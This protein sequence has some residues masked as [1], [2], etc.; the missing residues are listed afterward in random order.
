MA[1][2]KYWLGLEEYRQDAEV[3]QRRQNEFP[4]ELP[5]LDMVQD[6]AGNVPTKRRDF[7]KYMG[8][9]LTAATLASCEMPVRKAIPYVFAPE[10]T[11]PGIA[12]YYASTFADGSDYASILVKTRDGRPIKIEGNPQSSLTKGGTTARVQGS[13]LSLYDTNRKQHPSFD[14]KRQSWFQMDDAILSR[15]RL[16]AGQGRQIVLLTNSIVSPSTK[17]LIKD[18]SDKYGTVKHVAYDPVSYSGMLAANEQSFGKRALPHYRLDEAK[19]IVGFNADFLGTWLAPSQFAPQYAKHRKPKGEN[20]EMSRHIQF[21]SSMTITGAAAD[22]RHAMKPTQVRLALLH[23]YNQLANKMGAPII[24]GLANHTKSDQIKQVA[25]EL[26]R[27]QGQSLV[28]SGGNDKNEQL[29]V[30]AINDMLGNYGKTLDWAHESYYKQGDETALAKLIKDMDNGQVGAIIIHDCN[31]VYDNPL[32]AAFKDAVSKV[33]MRISTATA[34]NETDEV[35]QYEAPTHHFLESWTDAEPVRYHYSLGQ[36]AIRNIFDTRQFEDSLMI[37]MQDSLNE[38]DYADG[39]GMAQT[40][41]DGKDALPRKPYRSKFYDYI[42]GYWEQNVFPLQSKFAS[43]QAFWDK[44]LHDGV[45]E[46]AAP[47][48]EE[49]LVFN[50]DVAGASAKVIEATKGGE[51]YE[52]VFYE[53]VAIG[54]GQHADNPWLQEMPD[55]ITKAT[56]DNYILMSVADGDEAGI[57]HKDT[58]RVYTLKVNGQSVS[59]PVIVQPGLAK[60]TLAVAVGY[61]RTKSGKAGQDIGKSV[62]PMIGLKEGL[63]QY[64]ATDATAEATGD[65]H[66]IAQTQTHHVINSEG[67]L[68]QRTVIKEGILPTIEHTIHEIHEMRHEFQHLNEQTLYPGHEEEYAR[69]HHWKMSI[70]LNTCIGCGACTIACQAENNVPVV[71]KEEVIRVHEMHWIRIDRYYTGEDLENPDVVFQ[72]M[73]CQHCDNAPCENVCPVAA[74]NHSTEGLNQMAYNRCIG[75]R[76]CANNC[77][78]KVRRFNW[79]DYWGADSFP[80]NELDDYDMTSDLTRMVLNPDVTVRS[81]GVMEKCSFCVQRL[82]EGK[83]AAKKEGRKL[84]DSDIQ[85]ACMQACPTH[86]ITFGDINNTDSEVYD[87]LEN[88]GRTFYVI[89]EVNTRP[90]VGYQAKIRNRSA[91]E[92]AAR[93]GIAVE[94]HH[95]EEHKA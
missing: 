57:D 87:A 60:G 80:A 68:D 16:V 33:N 72:P 85:T 86:A 8:F 47:G 5:L 92:N 45:F 39:A 50:G 89:E 37:W 52:V 4:E 82:Q 58:G 31:P 71:G 12:T 35:V 84:Q 81:R 34:H 23:L 91:E 2:N 48:G 14:G 26:M 51:G 32:G 56:W 24:S 90:A 53:K 67:N 11:K 70:D 13:V 61:G 62:Y 78:Y 44:A 66:P 18:F 30:N 19:V 54:N 41:N 43:F 1:D 38:D 95:D 75:T 79:Y 46:A 27:H 25:D 73:M 69:G 49:I 76:Y 28:V 36:P 10:E 88:D 42:R 9:S 29:I 3:E 83:L 65:R 15:L 94:A 40:S 55:P 93:R 20:P 17:Q 74:T 21:E 7:L 59:L 64:T 6:E 63:M 77:P 22:V